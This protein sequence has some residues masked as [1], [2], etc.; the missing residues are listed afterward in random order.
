M[1]LSRDIA[2]LQVAV[3][4]VRQAHSTAGS[5]LASNPVALM[6][7]TGLAPDPWQLALLA[8]LRKQ[9]LL[10]CTR[11]GGKS[12]TTAGLA[13]ATAMRKARATV[14]LL[15]P[16]LRQSQELFAK[17]LRIFYDAGMPVAAERVSA[18]RMEFVHGSRII[19]LPADEKT[20]RGFSGIDLL[21]IDEASRV[22]DELY[23]S[24]RPMLAISGGQLIAL[25]TP[26]GK[27]GWFYDEW[28]SGGDSWERIRITADECPRITAEFLEEERRRMPSAWFAS[29]Y[30]CQF[31]DTIDAAFSSSD[32]E[33]AVTSDVRPL[34]ATPALEAAP[35]QAPLD[36]AFTYTELTR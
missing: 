19:A 6:Q 5:D 21:V 32:I 1:S 14:L 8:S 11:Q 20:I 35:L 30:Q 7:A 36:S 23:L 13:L 25:T 3:R 26:W 24:V 28:T 9:I 31:T 22:L 12:T 33:R 10:L 2:K 27:R 17:V 16:S 34:F 15:S 29:E 4:E 18:L